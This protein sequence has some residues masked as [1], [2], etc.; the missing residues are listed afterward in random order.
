MTHAEALLLELLRSL[1][2]LRVNGRPLPTL[3]T[4]LNNAVAAA[5]AE[6]TRK[7]IRVD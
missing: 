6:L 3:D 1:K 4:R 7:G 2:P 5:E